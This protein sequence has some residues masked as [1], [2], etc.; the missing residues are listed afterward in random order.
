MNLIRLLTRK[1]ALEQS[2]I[3]TTP[4]DPI[5][6][7]EALLV[8]HKV[9]LTTNNITSAAFGDAMQYWNFFPTGQPE[10]GHIP[11]WGFADVMA[12]NVLG[13]QVG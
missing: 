10:W 5:G 9:A 12:S 7:G 1:N 11:A 13:V 2:R 6:D 8:I 4:L 3:E